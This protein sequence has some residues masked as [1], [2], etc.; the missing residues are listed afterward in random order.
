M[1]R[2]FVLLNSESG[3][4]LECEVTE[5]ESK[6]DF[7]FTMCACLEQIFTFFTSYSSVL[8]LSKPFDL[9]KTTDFPSILAYK[10][11]SH[12]TSNFFNTVI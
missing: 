7:L 3:K 12:H 9:N 8:S 4:Y 6:F 5:M 10:Q 1:P 2:A 11:I